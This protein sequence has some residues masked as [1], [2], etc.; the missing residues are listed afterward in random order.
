MV[1]EIIQSREKFPRLQTSPQTIITKSLKTGC[2]SLPFGDSCK[3]V[4]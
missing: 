4:I 2:L 3:G 1:R